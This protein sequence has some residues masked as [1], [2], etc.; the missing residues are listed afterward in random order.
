MANDK[1]IG[2]ILTDNTITVSID[3]KTHMLGRDDAN[4]NKLIDALKNERF[5]EVPE[6]ISVAKLIE[7]YTQGNFKVE[8]GE[9]LIDGEPVHGLL[10]TKIKEFH[11]SDLPYM[12]LV[13]FARNVRQNPNQRA[14]NDLFAFLEYNGHPITDDGCFIAYKRV[15]KVGEGQFKDIHTGTMSISIGQTVNM[16]R[17]EVDDNPEQTCSRGL[18]ICSFG[19]LSSFGGSNDPILEVSVNPKDCVAFPTDYDMQKCRTCSYTVLSVVEKPLECS[20]RSVKS[21][22]PE[23]C[24]DCHETMYCDDCD[25]TIEEC[26]C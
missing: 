3:G 21:E 7:S 14:Q 11:A 23:D 12:P 6:L 9:V 15:R 26:M 16:P 2:W 18:H 19:Y 8:D 4:A 22:E 1:K 13:N 25:E 17:A 5:D 24:N 10:A 20:Y